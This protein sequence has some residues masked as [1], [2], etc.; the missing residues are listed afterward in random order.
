MNKKTLGIL[1]TILFIN[2]LIVL[3]HY[4]IVVGEWGYHADAV[5]A[6]EL[7]TNAEI[8]LSNADMAF[9]VLG[10]ELI[11]VSMLLALKATSRHK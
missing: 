7:A 5:K 8:S 2:G 11:I 10:L 1:S 3:I 4:W 6:G 9:V